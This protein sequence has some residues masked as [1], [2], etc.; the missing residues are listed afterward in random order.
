[1][2]SPRFDKWNHTIGIFVNAMLKF[3]KRTRNFFTTLFLN[4]LV[5]FVTHIWT[6][7]TFVSIANTISKYSPMTKVDTV[8]VGN[9][10]AF[11]KVYGLDKSIYRG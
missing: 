4:I 6:S 8:V 5:W 1:M 7:R 9:E 3:F 11:H 2:G 10:V